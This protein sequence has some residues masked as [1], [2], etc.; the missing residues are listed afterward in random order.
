MKE[1]GNLH[2]TKKIVNRLGTLKLD[3][4][5]TILEGIVTDT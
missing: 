1:N 4:Y 5:L 2:A 3:T